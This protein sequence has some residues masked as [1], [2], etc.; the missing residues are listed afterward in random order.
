MYERERTEVLPQRWTTSR[1]RSTEVNSASADSDS[2]VPRDLSRAS[3]A[4]DRSEAHTPYNHYAPSAGPPPL[5]GIMNESA[6]QLTTTYRPFAHI[7][8]SN[9][10]ASVDAMQERTYSNTSAT[11]NEGYTADIYRQAP[12]PR[13][14][15]ATASTSGY[16]NSASELPRHDAER[17]WQAAPY[18]SSYG[19]GSYAP[20]P[21]ERHEPY[22]LQQQAQS[23]P[24]GAPG[25]PPTAGIERHSP[26]LSTSSYPGGTSSSS[27]S[28]PSRRRGKLPR[29]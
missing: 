5:P 9:Y 22:P 25:Y 14:R 2:Q 11:S 29:K 1:G 3:T 19:V 27:A 8:Q 28:N 17:S 24:A 7:P 4:T 18:S 12:Y 20:Y 6:P 16:Y 26:P 23:T 21:T 10:Y 15:P 13:M